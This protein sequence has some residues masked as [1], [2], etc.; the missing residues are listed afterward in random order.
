MAD[1]ALPP[2]IPNGAIPIIRSAQAAGDLYTVPAGKLLHVVSVYVSIAQKAAAG[3][4]G[5]VEIVATELQGDANPR[6]LV[7]ASIDVNAAAT[8]GNS[9]DVMDVPVPA[10]KKVQLVLTNAAGATISG[11]FVGWEEPARVGTP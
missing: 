5:H 3:A 4:A 2:G 8:N 7:G 10:A 6:V 1:R 9:A 11:G